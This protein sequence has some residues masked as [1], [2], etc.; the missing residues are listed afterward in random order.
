M[1]IVI[2]PDSF[3]ESLSSEE[4]CR[5][6]EKGLR[7]AMP[8]ARLVKNPMADGGEGTMDT[9][10]KCSGG[11]IIKCKATDPLGGKITARCGLLDGGNTAL[12]EMAE[13]SGLALVP[14]GKRNPLK[15]SS[16]GTGEMIKFAIER[17][18][19]KILLTLGGIATN[20]AGVGI[21]E[22]LGYKF[23][24]ERGRNIPR[25][26]GGLKFL[27]HIDAKNAH[28]A[29]SKRAFL[30][31]CDVKNPLCGPNGSAAVYGPQKGATPGMVKEIEANL[32]NFARVVNNDLKKDVLNVPGAGAAGGAGAGALAFLN[33]SLKP[34]IEIVIELTRLEEKLKDA[35]L[36]ITGEGRM[37]GQTVFGKTPAGVAK[38]AKKYGLPVIAFCGQ[39]GEGAQKARAAG[40]DAIFSIADGPISYEY[41]LKNAGK[42][43]ENAVEQ[44]FG[45]MRVVMNMRV[46]SGND[47]ASGK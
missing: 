29:L 43:L 45:F 46:A 38:T 13:A 28:P 2:A 22:A 7:K 19:K 8:D 17:G 44:A 41:S 21:A 47:Y 20:D 18:C 35:D 25:G 12:I 11:R 30:A 15:T 36:V 34:G 1:I 4:A 6:I 26:A 33:A 39:I 32:R 23:L 9:I 5:A 10:V 3:K 42:L 14:R 24:D 27:R 16:Y 37:D 31:A 40:I